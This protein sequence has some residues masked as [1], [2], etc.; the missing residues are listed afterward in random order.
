MIFR[1]EN[2]AY[3]NIRCRYGKLRW[4]V[5]GHVR[6]AYQKKHLKLRTG[7]KLWIM[8]SDSV[9]YLPTSH[10][11]GKRN[12]YSPI[13]QWKPFPYLVGLMAG[14]VLSTMVLVRPDTRYINNVY[15]MISVDSDQTIKSEKILAEDLM[16]LEKRTSNL[17]LLSDQTAIK[18]TI[19][20]VIVEHSE[21][22]M[23][24]LMWATD[25]TQLNIYAPTDKQ[26]LDGNV[27]VISDS[28]TL[29]HF[30]S[31]IPK[32]APLVVL[33]RICKGTLKESHWVF[34]GPNSIYINT[35]SLRSYLT[36]LDSSKA[37]W[38]VG[39]TPDNKTCVWNSGMVFS[40][41]TLK[42]VCPAISKCIT[43]AVA[44]PEGGDP[45]VNCVEDTI[46]YTC[47]SQHPD[48]VRLYQLVIF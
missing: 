14:V 40:Y 6:H 32:L 24:Q 9:S 4:W 12:Y 37:I 33:W 3:E 8:S 25:V 36:G 30:H 41:G 1:V 15:V 28:T 43:D 21:N 2:F 16:R 19:N 13:Q 44:S 20:Y 5:I 45:L 38:L 17:P 10:N 11:L 27:D 42:M 7:E 34:F 29:T 48:N 46:G 47:T 31:D 26:A 23:S 22:H 18:E 35:V 39:L